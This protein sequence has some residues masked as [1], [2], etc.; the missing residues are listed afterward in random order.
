DVTGAVQA[1]VAPTSRQAALTE[2]ARRIRR[3]GGAVPRDQV[4]LV[5]GGALLALGGLVILVGW[6]GAAHTGRLFEQI[7]YL[8]S[9]GLL[10]LA[11]VVAGGFFYFG[12]WLTR[13]VQ[14]NRSQTAQLTGVLERI[15]A[16]LAGG[17][18]APPRAQGSGNGNRGSSRRRVGSGVAYVATSTGSLFHRPDCPVV[19]NRAEVRPVAAGGRGLRPCRICEP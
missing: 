4:L 10:G 14:E 6:Y 1:G 9:G 18:Q 13:L 3:R 17:A 5:A 11:L 15:E 19:A 2:A 16:A 8:I 7:P 12:Y